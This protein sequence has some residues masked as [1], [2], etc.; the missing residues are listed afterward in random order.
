M[1]IRIKEK[2]WMILN[3]NFKNEGGWTYRG[4]IGEVKLSVIDYIITNKKIAPEV[5]K[6]KE[7]NRVG[8]CAI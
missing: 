7:R 3:E 4:Q 5:K 8:P 2:G 1:M 6:I